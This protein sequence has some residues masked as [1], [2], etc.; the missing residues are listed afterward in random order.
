MGSY[1]RRKY[2]RASASFVQIASATV[3]LHWRMLMNFYSS[4]YKFRHRFWWNSEKV[5]LHIILFSTFCFRSNGCRHWKSFLSQG[6]TSSTALY[7]TFFCDMDKIRNG[8]V[9]KNI[10]SDSELHDKYH[11]EIH[12][13]LRGVNKSPSVPSTL[14]VR[15]AWY[16]VQDI[17][18]YS[19]NCLRVAWYLEQGRPYFSHWSIK[20]YIHTS[21]HNAIWNMQ[22]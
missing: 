6:R 2:C 14:I 15:F 19:R 12:T 8:N 7:P 22:A 5:S 1:L 10:S 16:P 20:N 11:S 9:H 18:P 4:F 3:N 21:S 13:L 17:C